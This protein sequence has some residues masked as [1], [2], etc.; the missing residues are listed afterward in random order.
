MPLT[1]RPWPLPSAPWVMRMRW[2]ELLFAHWRLDSNAARR[3]RSLLPAG[4]NLDTFD[5]HAYIGA[6]PFFMENV[7]PRFVPPFPGLHA[8]PE[9]NLRTYV[10]AGGKP[11]V[12]FFSLDAGGKL[13]VR[14][15]RRF[16]HLPYFD[17]AFR[18]EIARAVNYRCTRTHRGSPPA[19]FDAT[20]RPIGDPYRAQPGSLDHWLTGRYCFYSANSAHVVFRAE[21][22]HEPWPL[23][24]A[25]AEIRFNTLGDWL[26]IP[27]RGE[28]G[29]LHFSRRLDVHAWM[30][31]RLADADTPPSTAPPETLSW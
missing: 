24:R 25:E 10:T 3:I 9:L 11:G 20:Y 18:V 21:I 4:L 19:A 7:T 8:F 6:V 30:I 13:A 14:V 23:Q 5:G 1:P 28:P 12:W 15:A 31:H 27:M 29:A 16:F 17:A 26:G 22:D 2:L